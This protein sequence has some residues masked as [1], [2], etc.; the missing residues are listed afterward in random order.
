ML[1]KVMEG[2]E[3]I[4]S[5]ASEAMNP[6]KAAGTLHKTIFRSILQAMCTIV[7]GITELYIL[8]AP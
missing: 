6:K 3:L 8:E 5:I 2:Q 7:I 1:G 4:V